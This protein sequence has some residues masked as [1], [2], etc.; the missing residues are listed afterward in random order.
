MIE[1]QVENKCQNCPNFSPTV[2]Q[3]DIT[4]FGDKGRKYM[5]IVYCEEKDFCDN[6][7]EY[8]KNK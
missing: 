8:L 1:L 3:I 2:N 7:E 5:Q 6:A 4:S